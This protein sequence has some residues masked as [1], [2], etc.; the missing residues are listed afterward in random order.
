MMDKS[1]SKLCQQVAALLCDVSN[2]SPALL[3]HGMI[4]TG[5]SMR[6]R[7]V[8]SASCTSVVSLRRDETLRRRVVCR[9]ACRAHRRSAW[10]LPMRFIGLITDAAEWDNDIPPLPTLIM[11]DTR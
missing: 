7:K 2:V 10:G 3:Q 4:R 1:A 8:W 5:S 9:H 11:G 6:S